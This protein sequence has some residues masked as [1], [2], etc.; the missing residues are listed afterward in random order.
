MKE[1]IKCRVCGKQCNFKKYE[2]RDIVGTFG[3]TF[4]YECPGC[5]IEIPKTY[6][7]HNIN[8]QEFIKKMIEKN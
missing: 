1:K 4:F 5:K 6:A 8:Y 7:F 3:M 2:I